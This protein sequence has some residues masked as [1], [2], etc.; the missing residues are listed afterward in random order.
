MIQSMRRAT[1]SHLELTGI[2]DEQSSSK[3]RIQTIRGAGL[4]KEHPRCRGPQDSFGDNLARRVDNE[5]PISST[6]GH[7]AGNTVLHI[8]DDTRFRNFA[9]ST[10]S[11]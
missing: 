2:P 6:G 11:V 10:P 4:S 5:S 9:L 3:D 7:L 8:A 1:S